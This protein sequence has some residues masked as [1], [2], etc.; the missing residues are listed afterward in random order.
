MIQNKVLYFNYFKSHSNSFIYKVSLILIHDK[1]FKL[2]YAVDLT[3]SQQNI[4]FYLEITAM[5][6]R[7]ISFHIE[8]N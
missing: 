3:I 7:V 8:K 6:L 2:R 1:L 4:F 5:K